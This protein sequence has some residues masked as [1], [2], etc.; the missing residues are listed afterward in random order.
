VGRRARGGRGARGN[1]RSRREYE[2]ECDALG[3]I[4]KQADNAHHQCQ[5]YTDPR[6]PAESHQQATEKN[7]VRRGDERQPGSDWRPSQ[8]TV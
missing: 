8:P 7:Q 5:G 4:P 3:A 2:Y 1:N 6:E